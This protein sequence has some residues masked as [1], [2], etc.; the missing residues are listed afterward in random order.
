MTGIRTIEVDLPSTITL[1]VGDLSLLLKDLEQKNDEDY[2]AG[3]IWQAIV[4]LGYD[5]WQ[6]K[7]DGAWGY[8]DMVQWVGLT[9]GP[10][11]KMCILLGKYHQ[12]V[13]C[14]G[15]M[16]YYDNG[17]VGGGPSRPDKEL[18]LHQQ[19][20]HLMRSTGLVSIPLGKE[21]HDIASRFSVMEWDDDY[22]NSEEV[23]RDETVDDDYANA[24]QY[25]NDW[26]NIFNAIVRQVVQSSS[27]S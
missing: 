13:L 2:Q 10:F 3:G 5:E 19:M 7:P 15:H 27:E 17:Y 23:M 14:N 22:G 25:N 18:P 21:I 1:Q 16:G 20:L 12:Q 26:E 4:N 8:D 9:Y 6:K 11:A 24:A